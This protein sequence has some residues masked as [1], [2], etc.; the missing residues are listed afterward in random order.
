MLASLL[1]IWCSNVDLLNV[2]LTCSK[3]SQEIRPLL[4]KRK[5]ALN[6]QSQHRGRF[7]GFSPDDRHFLTIHDS[8]LSIWHVCDGTLSKQL[9]LPE[10][11]DCACMVNNLFTLKIDCELMIL[12]WKRQCFNTFRL[13]DNWVSQLD[14]FASTQIF[15]LY[16]AAKEIFDLWNLATN[17]HTY[18]PFKCSSVHEI[19]VSRCGNFIIVSTLEKELYLINLSTKKQTL[20]AKFEILHH[21][22]FGDQFFLC[23]YDSMTYLFDLD[24][25]CVEW[26]GLSSC[27]KIKTSACRPD[28]FAALLSIDSTAVMFIDAK[29]KQMRILYFDHIIITS[30][31]F[32]FNGRDLVC[33]EE[34]PHRYQ[35]VT[36]PSNLSSQ[37]FFV[38]RADL[39]KADE[40]F[41]SP[42]CNIVVFS[43][44]MYNDMEES[45][46]CHMFYK[47]YNH[48]LKQREYLYSLV[49]HIPSF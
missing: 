23:S 17:T 37:D 20:L 8:T 30:I 45:E 28:F 25:Q 49:P 21:L 7:V 43:F 44:S 3:W 39:D 29:Q 19:S 1:G 22:S 18:F 47:L 34:D 5:Q 35:I 14:F 48:D 9:E 24:G 10:R 2:A 16:Y 33:C 27:R 12:D 26:F 41:F 40:V 36:I 13:L 15:L 42:N 32:I 11:I 38:N 46:H 31:S 4:E 6:G